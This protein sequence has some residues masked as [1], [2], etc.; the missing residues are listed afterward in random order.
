MK[1]AEVKCAVT[2]VSADRDNLLKAC[3]LAMHIIEAEHG[4]CRVYQAHQIII[5]AAIADAEHSI[6]YSLR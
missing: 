3:K 5:R 2:R 6:K 1:A 4:A